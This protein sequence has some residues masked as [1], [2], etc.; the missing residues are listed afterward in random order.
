MMTAPAHSLLFVV[1]VGLHEHQLLTVLTDPLSI[2][3]AI[4]PKFAWLEGPVHTGKEA[5]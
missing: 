3:L 4:V 1:V 2:L 5:R